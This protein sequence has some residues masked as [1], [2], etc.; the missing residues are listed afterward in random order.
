MNPA[1]LTTIVAASLVGS[2]HCAGMCGPFVVLACSH[3]SVGT[4]SRR[5]LVAY[6]LGRLTTYLMLGLVAGVAGSALTWTGTTFGVSQLAA[7]VAG[8][9]M[10]VGGLISLARL[11]GVVIPSPR[12]PLKITVAIQSVFRR[13]ARWQSVTRAFAIGLATTWLP[14]GW[15]Y[16]FVLVAAGAGSV[17]GA[18]AVMLAFWV[19]TLPLLSGVCWATNLAGAR[20]R[21]ALPYLSAAVMILAGTHLLAT[22]SF[23]DFSPL[24]E[25]LERSSDTA[26]RLDRALSTRPACCHAR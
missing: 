22:R 14:C 18:A 8:V 4:A 25:S 1:F 17:L 16:A 23:A 24:K 26:T 20:W 15:L 7:I 2:L 5:A 19:G 13:T 3:Q 9:A 11:R 21:A 10:L 6:H 12:L